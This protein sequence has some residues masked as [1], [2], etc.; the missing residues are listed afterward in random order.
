MLIAEGAKILMQY[1]LC[2]D[3]EVAVLLL[4]SSD[5]M[6]AEKLRKVDR[7]PFSLTCIAL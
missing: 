7:W 2:G 4:E 6:K 5:E 3:R 1:F